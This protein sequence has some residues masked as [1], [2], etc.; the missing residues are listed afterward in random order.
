VRV[1]VHAVTAVWEEDGQS[2]TMNRRNSR[3][4]VA[5]RSEAQPL[6]LVRDCHNLPYPLRGKSTDFAINRRVPV[7]RPAAQSVTTA[8]TSP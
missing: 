3:I 1:C 8:A 7:Y 4:A 2:R 6:S 5:A